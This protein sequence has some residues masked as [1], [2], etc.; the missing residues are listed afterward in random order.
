MMCIV[1][2][3]SVARASVDEPFMPGWAIR[4]ESA[5]YGPDT[6]SIHIEA[7]DVSLF[8]LP[9]TRLSGIRSRRRQGRWIVAVAM[10]QLRT[11]LGSQSRYSAGCGV[12]G[13]RYRSIVTTA[14]ETF[15]VAVAPS[16]RVATIGFFQQIDV[17]DRW[18]VTIV[19]DGVHLTD[20]AAGGANVSIVA[21]TI[22]STQSAVAAGLEMHPVHGAGVLFS[23]RFAAPGPLAI[24]FGYDGPA[25]TPGVLLTIAVKH[26]RVSSAFRSHP[27]LG[28]SHGISVSWSR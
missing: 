2:W 16:D 23:A 8:G 4:T 18:G 21:S 13:Q 10:S 24:A 27:V 17:V 1:V 20:S 19:A 25:G 7:A 26:L 5:A 15:S 14:Y 28:I 22:T 6:S 12:A 9:D 3:G 11:P